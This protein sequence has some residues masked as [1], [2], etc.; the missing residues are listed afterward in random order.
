M[1]TFT[2]TEDY[3]ALNILTEAQLNS[4]AASVTAYFNNIV[5]NNMNQIA[6]DVFGNTYSYN[7]NGIQTQTPFLAQAAALIADNEIIT[8][9]WAFNG[10]ISFSNVV[11]STSTFTSSGQQRV[12]T[13]LNTVNQTITNNIEEVISF[14]ADSYDVGLMHDT[15]V[16]PNRITVP[17]GGT[18]LYAIVAQVRFDANATGRRE[19][20]LYKNG[21][22]VATV[23]DVSASASFDSYLQIAY[24]DQ[25]TAGDYYELY[26]YQNSGSSLDVVFGERNTFFCAMKVW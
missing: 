15:G 9:N 24:Q 13:Y 21:S 22:K 2:P 11:T 23:L 3:A 18:G 16:N 20:H 1:P 7:N 14:N 25:G 8:G 4:L 6:L 17:S 12:K 26:V 10:T 19:V 5:R